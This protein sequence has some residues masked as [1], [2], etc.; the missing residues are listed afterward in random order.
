MRP[1]LCLAS[2]VSAAALAG[3]SYVTYVVQFPQRVVY[4]VD[5]NQ[6]NYVTQDMVDKLKPDLSKAQVRLILG[7]PL[8][9]DPFHPNRWDYA[10]RFA[11]SGRLTEQRDFTVY[12][13]NDKLARWNGDA[14]P[15]PMYAELSAP[16]G[17]GASVAG[18]GAE[19]KPASSEEKRGFFGRIW[20][21]LSQ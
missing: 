19:S 1:W 20:D 21:W 17:A 13:D 14:A 18:A 15:A 10:Y 8:L 6:G 3:C 9:S 4:R 7:T 11:K 2:V 16:S 12:F 5:I